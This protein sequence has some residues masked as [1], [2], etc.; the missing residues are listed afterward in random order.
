MLRAL[1]AIW[2]IWGMNWVVMKVAN[3]YFP[4]VLFVT[5]RFASGA[6]VMLI[7]AIVMKVTLPK[8]Q[9]WPWL[10]ITGVLQIAIN[11]AIVQIG[12]MSLGAGMAAVLNYTMPLWVAIM[13]HFMLGERLTLPKFVGIFISLIGMYILM[14]LTALNDLTAACLT[15][16]GA[17]IWALAGVLTK[18]KLKGC[19]MMQIA[20]WQMIS[21]AVVLSIY[22]ATIPQ[23]EVIWN[24]SSVLMLL[25][26][27]VLASAAAFFI[28]NWLLMKIE[29]SKA[30]IAI[31]GVPVVGVLGG[32]VCLGEP[33]TLH[34]T[35]GMFLILLGIYLVVVQKNQR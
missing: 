31:L 4:P 28:W 16:F 32:I 33:L 24:I 34:T 1:S 5:Y 29:A 13:A 26:N 2:L 17:M 23:G 19:S 25:Y 7:A 6:L 11:S 21:G 10:I 22:S 20:T 9:F 30:S 35:L 8:T 14:G 12:M 15:I 3:G 18:M 27:G